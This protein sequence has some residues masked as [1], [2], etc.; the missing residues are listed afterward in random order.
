MECVD[1]C[2]LVADLFPRFLF[3]F[4]VAVGLVIYSMGC[5]V[6]R[7]LPGLSLASVAASFYISSLVQTV[8]WLVALAA[9]CVL[10]A[11]SN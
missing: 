9:C 6:C 3:T 5:R 1:R 4:F 10:L 2:E 8:G 7:L 11:V